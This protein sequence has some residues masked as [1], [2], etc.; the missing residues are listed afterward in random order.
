MHEMFNNWEYENNLDN[1]YQVVC[2]Y[3][4]FRLQI[5]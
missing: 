3:Y 2:I 4:E 5:L 1:P